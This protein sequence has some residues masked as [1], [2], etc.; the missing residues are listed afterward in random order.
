VISK[1]ISKKLNNKKYK[2]SKT[3]YSNIFNKKLSPL[4][5]LRKCGRAEIEIFKKEH[6]RLFRTEMTAIYLKQTLHYF[7]DDFKKASTYP[8]EMWENS[9]NFIFSN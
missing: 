2:K 3:Q 8:C 5:T 1:L 9:L 4:A 6:M 7:I